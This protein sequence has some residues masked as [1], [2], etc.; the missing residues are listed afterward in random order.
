MAASSMNRAAEGRCRVFTGRVGA[1]ACEKGKI[2]SDIPPEVAQMGLNLADLTIRNTAN[3][4]GDRVR[5][6][7]ANRDHAS[8]VTELTEI[9][10]DLLADK[11]DLITLG[12]LLNQ[13]LASQVI[14]DEDLQFITETLIPTVEKL[15]EKGDSEDRGERVAQLDAIKTLVAPEMLAVLQLVGFNFREAIGVPLTELVASLIRR[16]VVPPSVD[17]STLMELEL[18]RQVLLLEVAKDNAASNRATRLTDAA[19]EAGTKQPQSQRRRK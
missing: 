11:T 17:Q 2:L 6:A 19:Q 10:N 5:T 9:I 1:L 15:L 3:L 12:Q 8:Q 13:Q 14:A 4:I 7:K 16:T 18:R